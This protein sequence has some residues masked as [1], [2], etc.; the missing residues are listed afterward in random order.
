MRVARSKVCQR[1][2]LLKRWRFFYKV[3]PFVR[4]DTKSQERRAPE[5]RGAEIRISGTIGRP[6]LGMAVFT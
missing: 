6:W 5:A 2:A 3:A 4:H 1:L